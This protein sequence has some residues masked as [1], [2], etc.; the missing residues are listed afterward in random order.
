MIQEPVGSGGGEGCVWSKHVVYMYEITKV[1]F[2][3]PILNHQF[4]EGVD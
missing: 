1:S 3:C 2:K 4:I